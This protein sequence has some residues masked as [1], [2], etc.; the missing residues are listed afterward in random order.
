MSTIRK[1]RSQANKVKST[2]TQSRKGREAHRGARRWRTSARDRALGTPG[3]REDQAS[4]SC[5]PGKLG[6]TQDGQRMAAMQRFVRRKAS[7]PEHSGVFVV[8][9]GT[10][11]GGLWGRGPCGCRVTSTKTH[12]SSWFWNLRQQMV[13][14]GL[15]TAV[16]PTPSGPPSQPGASAASSAVFASATPAWTEG[17]R[18][19]ASH[20]PW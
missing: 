13:V 12:V 14:G 16:S 4:A 10:G 1:E 7:R 18:T 6:N 5:R 19:P 3:N 15:E 2:C 8:G 11:R 20:P 9:E 17:P